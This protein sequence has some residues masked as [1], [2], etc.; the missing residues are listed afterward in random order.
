MDQFF[1]TILGDRTNGLA[2]LGFRVQ[3][4]TSWGHAF[5][6]FPDQLAEIVETVDEHAS[7]Q[8]A[9]FSPVLYNQER[10]LKANVVDEVW[11]LWADLDFCA[12]E[13]CEPKPAIAT[14]TSP[15]RYQGYWPLE[16]SIS[17]REA[18]DLNRKIAYAYREHG[19][20][21]SGWP[22]NKFL[23]IPGT[24]NHKYPDKPLVTVLWSEPTRF[25]PSDF[26]NL[27]TPPKR[28]V[29]GDATL[30]NQVA[31]AE[32]YQGRVDGFVRTINERVVAGRF[33]KEGAKG[34]SFSDARFN[35][36]C[37]F[38]EIGLPP[39]MFVAA[40]RG[41]VVFD[42]DANFETDLNGALG[43]HPHAELTC[44]EFG[45]CENAR[46]TTKLKLKKKVASKSA[47][48][49]DARLAETVA[50]DVMAD[51]YC[52]TDA[53][54]WMKWNGVHW[55]SCSQAN[56]IEA[57]RLHFL[58]QFEREV[59]AG[60]TDE[61]RA[62]L[63]KLLSKARIEATTALAKGIVIKDAAKF[64]QFPNLLNTPNGVLD[65]TTKQLLPHDPKLLMT[66]VTAVPYDRNAEDKDWNTAL[67][68]LPEDVR[69]WYQL[70]L[71]QAITGFMPPDD[72]L[73]ICQGGGENGKTTLNMT[74]A[75]ALGDYY[76]L[77]SD[78]VLMADPKAHTTELMDLRG[79][80]MGIIEETPEVAHLSVARLK[81]VIG[82]PEITA[83]N[84]YK[85]SVTFTVTHTMFLSTN[86]KPLVEET[87]HGT[88][89]RLA[90]VRFPYRFLKPGQPLTSKNDRHGDPG[91]RDRLM[92]EDPGKRA[93]LAWMVEGAYRWFQL[94]KVMP[95]L[96]TTVEA[97]TRTWRKE[98]DLILRYI[99]ENLVLDDEAH[100]LSFEL[101]SHF[102]EW[103]KEQGHR[104][105]SAKT[106]A[107]RFGSHD[108]LQGRVSAKLMRHRD[109]LSRTG[110]HHAVS[111]TPPASYR[112]WLG[113][114]FTTDSEHAV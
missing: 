32:K 60:C 77:V 7:E 107:S 45:E 42:N 75:K 24:P 88:W 5:A 53:F 108:E 71:G 12:P 69:D 82:T 13:L 100:V 113:V 101:L 38:L 4:S 76:V 102:N 109:G 66:R 34:H 79:C 36:L 18:E 14:E 35:L 29:R 78:K 20:D 54:G 94:Q 49:S 40:T 21:V 22:S 86:Y 103:L 51:R 61:R 64:D 33:V 91:L 87:D 1:R 95:P 96:P 62:S 84:V 67:Q 55:E 90:L 31:I 65:L 59:R 56:V 74:A 110:L 27:P 47:E 80:R 68:A 26:D 3:G 81:K 23:R 97:D 98:S 2:C 50:N 46:Q 73:A 10:R 43:K 70:R 106:F 99:D 72:L 19:A 6:A 93:A 111:S 11:S 9:Y 48:F 16:H 25:R 92:N 114:R 89:R 15:G 58:S 44:D 112:A 8:N 85:D 37:S 17:A 39:S 28:I 83:R 30:P 63:Q 52:W 41:C 57:V 104:E 105:W